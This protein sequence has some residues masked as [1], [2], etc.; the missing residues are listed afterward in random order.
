MVP[1]VPNSG[2][3]VPGL[4]WLARRHLPSPPITFHV[5]RYLP[6]YLP[7][8]SVNYRR[9]AVRVRSGPARHGTGWDCS[10]VD[11]GR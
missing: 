2:A 3:R 8:P 10:M 7:N 9:H 1:Q 11:A 4:D 6:T 5:P